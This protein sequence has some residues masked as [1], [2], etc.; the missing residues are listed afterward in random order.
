MRTHLT[1]AWRNASVGWVSAFRGHIGIDA[2]ALD[3]GV[4]ADHGGL[5]GTVVV[6]HQ[7]VLDLCC[8]S[9]WPDTLITSSTRPVIQQ[10]PSASRRQ[11]SPVKYLPG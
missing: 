4:V 1:R 7:G 2:L 9:R 5:G 11:P 8:L 3:I 10:V 6:A